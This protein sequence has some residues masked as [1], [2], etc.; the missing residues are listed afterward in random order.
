MIHME[1]NPYAKHNESN[2]YLLHV[3]RNVRTK[4][5]CLIHCLEL[6]DKHSHSNL[7]H[8]W[9]MSPYFNTSSLYFTMKTKLSDVVSV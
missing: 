7:S 1:I 3:Y 9:M 2:D 6:G 8:Y 4:K 5:A